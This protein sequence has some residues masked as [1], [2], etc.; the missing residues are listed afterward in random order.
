MQQDEQPTVMHADFT[1]GSVDALRLL[2]GRCGTHQVDGD[3]GQPAFHLLMSSRDVASECGSQAMSLSVKYS[4][5]CDAHRLT[6]MSRM[7]F[8]ARVARELLPTTA[9]AILG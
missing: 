1:H 5:G 7:S 9:G 8:S 6:R 2:C 4:V 3:R